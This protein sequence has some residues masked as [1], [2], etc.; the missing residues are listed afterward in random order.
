MMLRTM[1]G[2][3][4]GI[5]PIRRSDIFTFNTSD[6]LRRVKSLPRSLM[7]LIAHYRRHPEDFTM[8]DLLHAAADVLPSALY[9]SMALERYIRSLLSSTGRTNRFDRLPHTLNIIAT[10][11]QSGE[12]AVFG[13]DE[14]GGVPI[15]LAVAASASVPMLYTPVR[16]DGREYVDGGLRG[17]ASLDLAVEKGAQLIVCINPLVP[18][19]GTRWEDG[20]YMSDEGMQVIL[21][22][23][24][25]ITLHSGLHYHVKQLRRRHPDV[26]IILIEPQPDDI[27]M[28]SAQIMRYSIRMMIAAHGYESVARELAADYYRHQATLARHGITTAPKRAFPSQNPMT[29]PLETSAN[30]AHPATELPPTVALDETLAELERLL[31]NWRVPA[32][33]N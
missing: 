26:D 1:G 23:V 22:Q 15:S 16:I 25:R 11:L 4:G 17:N 5:R 18:F 14:Q 21:D 6:L 29:V 28:F 9:D 32:S 24:L 30:G 7:N 10:D 19:D 13:P 12:R 20:H 8:F 3:E 31:L 2:E 33:S 27:Q